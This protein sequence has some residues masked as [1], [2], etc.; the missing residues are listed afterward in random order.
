MTTERRAA[1][2]DASGLSADDRRLEEYQRATYRFNAPPDRLDFSRKPATDYFARL[3]ALRLRAVRRHYR[4][5]LV[6][7]LCCGAGD[8][9][10]PIAM[11]T[12]SVVGVDFSGEL[13]NT[14]A[15]RA[16]DAGAANVH[17]VLGNAR[18]LPLASGCAGLVFAFS[19]L[20]Y[21]PRVEQ[22][23]AECARVLRPGGVALLEFGMQRSLNTLVAR[24][25]PEVAVSC[26]VTA[27]AMR[28]AVAGA[29][30]TVEEDHA[31]QVLPLW[32]DR[33]RW[34]APLLHPR[35]KSLL[36]HEVGGCMLDEWLS[37]AWP[38]RALAFR[39]LLV[40]RKPAATGGRP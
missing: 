22:V 29:G 20:Y 31:F 12:E 7:D 16:A 17:Y 9:A 38:F 4:D 8:Y 33:P 1:P 36:A 3:A 5:G 23:I 40:C 14:A 32:G 35:W 11:F 13:L 21:V 18:A 26:H 25:H 39:R 10:L 2:N 6:L 27:R 34:L 28:A 15:R 37:G 24:A 30:F 19:A